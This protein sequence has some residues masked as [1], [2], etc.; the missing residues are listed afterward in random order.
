MGQGFPRPKFGLLG[1]LKKSFA[2]FSLEEG[3]RLSFVSCTLPEQGDLLEKVLFVE[4]A[5]EESQA[6]LE[7]YK[8]EAKSLLPPVSSA[9]KQRK[10][11]RIRYNNPSSLGLQS[12]HLNKTR[13]GRMATR[14]YNPPNPLPKGQTDGGYNP[15]AAGDL[16]GWDRTWF[17]QGQ[18]YPY[19]HQ[20]YWAPQQ[21]RYW[22]QSYQDQDYYG[23]KNQGYQDQGYYGNKNQGYQD[24]GYYGN[25][26]YAYDSYHYQGY[27]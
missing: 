12:Y 21:L 7:G 11:P 4:L 2:G 19:G 24:Q 9:P 16:R 26:N 3:G 15:V 13:F 23:N 6:L 1:S 5:R 22:N 27:C 18:P 10:K 14:D 20:Q 8:K 25:R 17:N